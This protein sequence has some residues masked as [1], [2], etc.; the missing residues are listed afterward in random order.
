MGW[1]DQRPSTTMGAEVGGLPFPPRPPRSRFRPQLVEAGDGAIAVR[2]R[3]VSNAAPPSATRAIAAA[4]PIAPLSQSNPPSVL[5]GGPEASV[6]SLEA[7]PV[8]ALSDE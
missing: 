7:V 6:G 5:A 3:T 8:I 1:A 2:L 4:A